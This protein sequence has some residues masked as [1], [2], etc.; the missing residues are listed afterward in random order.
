LPEVAVLPWGATEPHNLHLPFGTDSFQAE[1]V[2]VEASRIASESGARVIVLPAIP[3]G[4]NAQ[5]LST[6]LTLNLHP[7]TQALVLADILESLEHHG[8]RKLL[9]LNG[10]GGNDFKQIVRELQPGFDVF[11]CCSNWWSVLDA[12][13][14]F[15][16]PG[17]HAGE[18]ETSVMLHLRPDLVL[19][20][21]EAG[22][23][24]TRRFR[25]KGLRQGVAWAPRD[26]ASVS[27]DT[28][29]GDPS[30]ATEAKGEQ[31]FR[32]VCRTLAD[33]LVELSDAD[34]LDLYEADGPDI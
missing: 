9:V 11:I 3:I 10:H 2:A 16:E 5:Q 23:G 1:A 6:P 25:L 20:L 32:D 4:A 17:D 22:S 27:E 12:S 14:Y 8:V 7:S 31:F 18:L 19:P 28:G 24:P 30:A 15:E 13:E 26:W 34:V 29:V 21:S 33:F